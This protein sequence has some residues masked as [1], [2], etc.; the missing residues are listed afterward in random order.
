MAP[1]PVM[2]LW[3]VIKEASVWVSGRELINKIRGTK[4]KMV[5]NG[6]DNAAKRSNLLRYENVVRIPN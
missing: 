5:I 1:T 3:G 2:I 6:N 4:L